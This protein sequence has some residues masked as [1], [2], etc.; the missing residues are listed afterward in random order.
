[1]MKIYKK[2]QME[3]STLVKLV[4]LLVVLAVILLFFTGG[5]KAIGTEKFVTVAN[6]ST[7][8]PDTGV[9]NLSTNITGWFG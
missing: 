3:L 2:G 9:S 4:I 6:E 5:F 7:P 1:M 8:T